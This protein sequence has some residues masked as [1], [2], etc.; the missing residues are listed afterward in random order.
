MQLG[1]TEK[2]LLDHYA[3]ELKRISGE[4][5][6][7]QRNLR[8]RKQKII[9]PRKCTIPACQKVT[10]Q[11]RQEC[12]I[13]GEKVNG[14]T[15]SFN[16]HINQCLKKTPVAPKEEIVSIDDEG[17]GHPQYSEQNI[18]EVSKLKYSCSEEDLNVRQIIA[19]VNN[20]PS[21]PPKMHKV[22]SRCRICIDAFTDPVVSVV[23]WHVYCE[24]CWLQSMAYRKTCPQCQA[25]VQPQDLR[26]V[27][28]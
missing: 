22:E 7:T 23:C 10:K 16:N 13:C 28:M 21:R 14:D 17:F 11:K 18:V 12:F 4:D 26:R 27:Y 15:E 9:Y 2:E 8:P 24:E 20:V 1:P 5:I 3:T 25:I 19:C 6:S